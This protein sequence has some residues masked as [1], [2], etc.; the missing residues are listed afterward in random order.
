MA[1]RGSAGARPTPGK[2][3]KKRP[4]SLVPQ[5][6]SGGGRRVQ[7][8]AD[9][10]VGWVQRFGVRNGGLVSMTADPS[11]VVLTAVDGTTARLVAPFGPMALDGREPLEAL[12]EHIAGIG[13]IGI[14]LVRAGAHAAGTA[15]GGAVLSSSTH[16]AYVQ[17]RTAAGGWSQQRYARRRGNQLDA[18][19]DH[20]AQVAAQVLVP[21]LA[22]GLDGLAVGGDL[23]A[24]TAVLGDPELAGLAAL[25]RRMFGDVP[26]PRRVV[27]DEVAE[28]ALLVEIEIRP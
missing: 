2:P 28:R 19:L 22:E 9:R 7:V 24:L 11:A 20:A 12:L 25:P 14:L 4:V 6:I 3:P 26:E 18:S 23:G 15:R 13:V 1:G 27:L 10:L 16:R 5:E 8:P 21:A 17:G